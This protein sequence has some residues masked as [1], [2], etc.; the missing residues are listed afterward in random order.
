[1]INLQLI[2]QIVKEYKKGLKSRYFSATGE[3]ARK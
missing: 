3:E 2:E 1:M